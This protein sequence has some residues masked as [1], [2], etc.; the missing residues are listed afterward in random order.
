M[1]YIS[2]LIIGQC[3][4]VSASRKRASDETFVPNSKMVNL[5]MVAENLKPAKFT[6]ICTLLNEFVRAD[7]NGRRHDFILSDYEVKAAYIEYLLQQILFGSTQHNKFACEDD[8]EILVKH[9]GYSLTKR[10]LRQLYLAKN[11]TIATVDAYLS[12]LAQTRC[13]SPADV[14]LA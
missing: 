13:Q 4:P 7:S 3:K 9:A 8:A 1:H 14:Q 12:L 6:S 11:V 2:N 10:D 5:K